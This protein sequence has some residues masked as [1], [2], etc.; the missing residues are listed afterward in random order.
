MS[1]VKCRCGNYVLFEPAP[2]TESVKVLCHRCGSRIRVKVRTPES[3]HSGDDH[4]VQ[5]GF[6][7]FFCPCGRRLKVISQIPLPSHGRCP[8]CGRT[9]PVPPQKSLKVTNP[10]EVPTTE[11]SAEEARNFAAWLSKFHE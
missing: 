4:R 8:D 5:D 3:R 11:L 2:G 6:I 7:R 10:L 1:R 9:V